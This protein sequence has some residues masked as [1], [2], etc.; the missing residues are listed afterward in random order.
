[1]RKVFFFLVVLCLVVLVV[2][3]KVGVQVKE[4]VT[5]K[6]QP[7]PAV[8]APPDKKKVLEVTWATD[9][10][11]AEVSAEEALANKHGLSWGDVV[12]LNVSR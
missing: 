12:P 3:L 8:Q 7:R 1:M 11:V 9:K 5:P 6:F 2:W 4:S 10:K